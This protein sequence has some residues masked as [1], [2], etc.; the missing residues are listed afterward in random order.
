MNSMGGRTVSPV[1][2]PPLPRSVPFRADLTS[3]LT[4][5]Y[6]HGGPGGPTTPSNAQFFDPAVY[7][8]VLWDQRG[9]GKSRPR[10]ELARNTTQD[11]CEDIERLRTHLGIG[12]WHMVFG[13]SWGSTLGLFYTQAHPDRVRSLVV[14]GVLT[15]RT[16]ELL[17][18]NA[19]PVAAQF[20][21]E[22]WAAFLEPL[23]DEERA[24]PMEA[25]YRRITSDDPV[26]SA[27]AARQW[28]MWEWSVATLRGGTAGKEKIED[29][30]WS[31][32]HALFEAHYLF[33][34]G[35][36]LEEGQLLMPENMARMKHIPG[37]QVHASSVP[38]IDTANAP[39]CC[40]RDCPGT[41]RCPLPARDGLGTT[42]GVA[43]LIPF[44]HQRCRTLGQCKSCSLSALLLLHRPDSLAD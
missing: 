39:P 32:T 6:L 35:A 19:Q 28:N 24:D 20:F 36:W 18:C 25:Y 41:L 40:R 7:R 29:P 16:S 21:P 4:V 44:P 13:G 14:R 26:V 3:V 42:Q 27:A 8:V 9:V 5:I 43:Q 10:N 22:E 31:F 12:Q 15:A 34:N 33:R 1:R 17:L 23:T 2:T 11:L 38:E 37:E 30:E